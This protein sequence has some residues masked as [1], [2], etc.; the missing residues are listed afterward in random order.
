MRTPKRKEREKR[1]KKEKEKKRKR[2]KDWSKKEKRHFLPKK[3]QTAFQ[4]QL[5]K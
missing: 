1:E 4:G 5:K 2:E 3:T